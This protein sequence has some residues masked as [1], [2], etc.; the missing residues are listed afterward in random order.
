MDLSGIGP[1]LRHARERV[2]LSQE[3]AA[4]AVGLSRVVLAYYETG[5]RQPSLAALTALARLYQVQ[6]SYLLGET[7][8]ELATEG[9]LSSLL[10]RSAPEE[11]TDEP[12]AG[13]LR[14]TALVRA[15]SDL[16]RELGAELPGRQTSWFP[17]ARPRAGRKEA[18]RLAREVRND[19]GLGDGPI[20][21]YLFRLLDEHA[22]IFRLSLGQVLDHSPSG[23][24]CN[25]R[26]AGFCIVV[27]SDMTLGRQVFTLAHEL[28]HAYFHSQEADVWISFPGSAAGRER[29]ADYF[30][31]EFLVPTDALARALDELDAWERL[32]D[33][34]LAVHL[35]RH[36]GVSYGTLLFRLRQE[37]LIE[38]SVYAQL[39]EISPSKLA[40]ALGYDVQPADMGDYELPPLER[41]PIR[42]LRLIRAALAHGRITKGDAAE[43][44]GVS[45]EDIIRLHGKPRADARER[46][47]IR[48]IEQ[49]A[50]FGD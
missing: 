7:D 20:G 41:F 24:F 9:E 2:G 43:T 50:R 30:A 38:A 35:Q 25:H 40:I 16:A 39:R 26:E 1:R 22:L 8:K 18:A 14:F 13:M 44:L 3:A 28:S 31:G 12:K 10:F 19:L 27:N 48:D 32:D 23:F 46:E 5:A 17:P 49:V 36:F 4:E 6:P 45:L 21:D 37:R 29:F 33:P 47:A 15:Y 34:I 11:L 42:M